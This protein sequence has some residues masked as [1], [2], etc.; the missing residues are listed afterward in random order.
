MKLV[1]AQDEYGWGLAAYS[2]RLEID[3]SR[4]RVI[5]LSNLDRKQLMSMF[6]HEQLAMMLIS[7]GKQL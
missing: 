3:T 7:A 6:T 2:T 1:I 5:D 4:K